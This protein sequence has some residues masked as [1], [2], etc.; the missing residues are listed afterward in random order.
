M[1]F[2]SGRHDKRRSD[3]IDSTSWKKTLPRLEIAL[4]SSSYLWFL[5]V[6][7]GRTAVVLVFCFT[8]LRIFGKREIG[9][10]NGYDIAFIRALANSIQNAMTMGKGEITLGIVSAGTLLLIGRAASSLFLKRPEFENRIIGCPVVLVSEGR[11]SKEHLTRE[12]VSEDELIQVIRTHGLSKV[13]QVRLAV[14]EVDGSI[15]IIPKHT[16]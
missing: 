15:S 12:R 9:Q 6:I 1:R 3:N 13:Q 5:S 8:A 16:D 4:M 10:F 2:G 14:L 7:A 11:V